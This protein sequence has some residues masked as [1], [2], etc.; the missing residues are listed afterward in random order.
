MLSVPLGH[1]RGIS[2]VL[3]PLDAKVEPLWQVA[4]KVH[5]PV[6]GSFMPCEHVVSRDIWHLSSVMFSVPPSQVAIREHKS[7]VASKVV[8]DAH[9]FVKARAHLSADV[10]KIAPDEHVD[11]IPHLSVKVFIAPIEH[12]G[13]AIHALDEPSYHMPYGHDFEKDR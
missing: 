9:T 12:V 7:L 6:T 4:V 1:V 8:P 11:T 5:L 3:H 10:S 2:F 13:S